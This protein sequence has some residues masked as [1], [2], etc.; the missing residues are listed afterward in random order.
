MTRPDFWIAEWESGGQS[1]YP[2]AT[3]AYESAEM[4]GRVIERLRPYQYGEQ[5][6]G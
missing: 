4:E 2:T 1:V 5:I 6:D 3:V